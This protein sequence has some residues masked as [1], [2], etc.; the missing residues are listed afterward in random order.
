MSNEVDG[1]AGAGS[2]IAGD[3]CCRLQ[4][5]DNPYPDAIANTSAHTRAH[6][7]TD[8][9]IHVFSNPHSYT[10]TC[11]YTHTVTYANAYSDPLPCHSGLGSPIQRPR[12]RL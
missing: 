2:G 12:E 1:D 9:C 3:A 7:C 5:R 6:S 8:T 11:T 4:Q 10:D